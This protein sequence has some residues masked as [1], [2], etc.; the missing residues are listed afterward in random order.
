MIRIETDRPEIILD[1][2]AT[3][4]PF[5]VARLD[6]GDDIQSYTTDGP[7]T[8]G[9]GDKGVWTSHASASNFRRVRDRGVE[10]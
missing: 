7:W 8:N 6:L 3:E 2:R 5:E 10:S 4:A 9:A 1:S